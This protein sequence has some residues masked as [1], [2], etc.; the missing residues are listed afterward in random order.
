MFVF[1]STM[2]IAAPDPTQRMRNSATYVANFHPDR[3]S[4]LS[5]RNKLVLLNTTS[6]QLC[7]PACQAGD[8]PYRLNVDPAKLLIFFSLSAEG[9]FSFFGF[10]FVGVG[11]AFI[12]F[13]QCNVFFAIHKISPRFLF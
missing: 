8:I 12:A 3:N 13:R 7:Q 5:L 9:L 1:E 11:F 6:I 2:P 10:V 4:C